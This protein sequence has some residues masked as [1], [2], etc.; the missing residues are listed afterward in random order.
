RAVLGA[1]RGQGQLPAPVRAAAEAAL[2][3]EVHDAL[4]LGDYAEARGLL[5]SFAGEAEGAQ[6][7]RSLALARVMAAEQ[8]GRYAEALAVLDGVLAEM[9]AEDPM[10]RSLAVV[11]EALA[12][13]A[14]SEGRLGGSEPATASSVVGLDL[15]AS[16]VLGAPYP[17]PSH[18]AAVVPL[19]LAE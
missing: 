18:G 11:A 10:R 1:G 13:Q 8:A 16:D 9:E 19:V 5:A 4:R 7:R 15:A 12:E 17:N 3:A 2:V 6:A 14:G